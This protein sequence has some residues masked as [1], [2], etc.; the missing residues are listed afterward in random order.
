[1]KKKRIAIIFVL[2]S[3]VTLLFGCSNNEYEKYGN[4]EVTFYLEGGTY[5]SSKQPIIYRYDLKNDT[6]KI[7]NPLDLM[8]ST[9]TIEKSGYELKGWYLNKEEKDGIV[10]YTGKW[11]FDTDVI[12]SNDI[13]DGIKLYA[14]WHIKKVYSYDIYYIDEN[15]EEQ[16]LLNKEVN[17]GGRLLED[18]AEDALDGYTFIKYTNVDGTAWD[19][20]FKHPGGDNETPIKVIAL[21]EK[22]VY[23]VVRTKTDLTNA[24]KNAKNNIYLDSDID[25]EGAT[26]YFKNYRGTLKGNNHKIYNFSLN[27]IPGGNLKN[28]LEDNVLYVSLF[29]DIENALI[30]NVS[31]ENVSLELDAGL[32]TIRE[33]Y[34]LPL[35]RKMINS[36]I[37]N[38][39]FTGTYQVVKY[40]ESENFNINEHFKVIEKESLE[41]DEASIVSSNKIEFTK[42]EKEN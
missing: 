32:P 24:L 16:F 21:Y 14:N 13:K 40:P 12:D 25:M 8:N 42:I 38:V 19:T 11:D 7:K 29:G 33:I 28:S 17:E 18:V 39:V 10:T 3:F 15:G 34:L 41:Q 2:I 36:K 22:G 6:M 30:E 20:D 37:N 26:V 9:Y 23:K 1:M 27:P 4:V 35:A 5:K 31:F